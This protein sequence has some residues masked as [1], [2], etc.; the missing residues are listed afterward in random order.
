MNFLLNSAR[1][2]FLKQTL[3]DLYIWDFIWYPS[4][5]MSLLICS[6]LMLVKLLG[7]MIFHNTDASQHN[8]TTYMHKFMSLLVRIL[9]LPILSQ[10][11]TY[12]IPCTF[13]I[14]LEP[15]LFIM[16][17]AV[18]YISNVYDN[19]NHLLFFRIIQYNAD[20]HNTYA[21]SPLWTHVRK[22]YPYE[23]LRRTEPAD[24]EIHEVTIG[25]SLS[26]GTLP[27]TESIW[28]DLDIA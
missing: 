3:T 6:S 17:Y 12:E 9:W 14:Q 28:K 27:T 22:P 1:F 11:V 18:E 10:Y 19:I 16:I 20:A 7:S 5:N 4:T 13:P 21:H 8:V 15:W 26:T 25:A 24:L 2:D 23:H